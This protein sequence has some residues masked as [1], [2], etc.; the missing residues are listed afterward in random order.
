MFCLSDAN[1]KQHKPRGFIKKD[2]SYLFYLCPNGYSFE[3]HFLFLGAAV[4][5]LAAA[6]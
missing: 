5:L 4:V 3:D 2:H 6:R 1:S